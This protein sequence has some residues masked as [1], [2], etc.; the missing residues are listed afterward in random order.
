[1]FGQHKVP[2]T[3]YSYSV[4]ISVIDI[5]TIWAIPWMIHQLGITQWKDPVP[6]SRNRT[7][8][9]LVSYSPVKCRVTLSVVRQA[10][11][12]S[13]WAWSGFSGRMFCAEKLVPSEISNMANVYRRTG[14]W[15]L[16]EWRR[17]NGTI[18]VARLFLRLRKRLSWLQKQAANQ[19]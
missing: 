7:R 9:R 10:S 19:P 4:I 3:R 6:R 5:S 8:A 11:G 1:M 14:T 2:T 18:T 17:K 12:A 15:L 16:G 13:V